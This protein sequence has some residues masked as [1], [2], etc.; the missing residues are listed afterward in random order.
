MELYSKWFV[1]DLV[2]VVIEQSQSGTPDLSFRP[3]VVDEQN[4]L[5]LIWKQSSSL[6]PNVA[7]VCE[8]L[9][10]ICTIGCVLEFMSK[11]CLDVKFQHPMFFSL[12]VKDDRFSIS[13]VFRVS[14]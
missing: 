2:I 9:E 3:C 5:V 8:L 13:L 1:I 14:L 10:L 7:I 6:G 4:E 12:E 11:C